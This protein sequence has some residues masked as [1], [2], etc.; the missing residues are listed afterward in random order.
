MYLFTVTVKKGAAPTLQ[1][2]SVPYSIICTLCVLYHPQDAHHPRC[3]PTLGRGQVCECWSP[4]A[5]A[6]AEL[7]AGCPAP[8]TVGRPA[9]PGR[10][11][12]VQSGPA[13]RDDGQMLQVVKSSVADPVGS[14]PFCWIRIRSNCPDP[15]LKSHKT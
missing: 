15:T 7:C 3:Y 10:R 9:S 8:W 2:S 5:G 11:P 6:D 13:G 14:E 4:P 1:H 12:R